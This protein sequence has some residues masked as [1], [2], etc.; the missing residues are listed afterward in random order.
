MG[1]NAGQSINKSCLKDSSL[2]MDVIYFSVPDIFPI[3][4][5][6]GATISKD[7][8]MALIIGKISLGLK[9]KVGPY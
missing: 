2:F 5:K 1:G 9:S 4:I 8:S 3:E 7:F 6:S